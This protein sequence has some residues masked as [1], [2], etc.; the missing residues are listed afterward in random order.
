MYCD[1]KSGTVADFRLSYGKVLSSRSKIISINRN[2]EQMTKN[3]DMFWKPTLAIQSDPASF[4]VK[5]AEA[6][7]T[8]GPED[9]LKSLREKDNAKEI[10]NK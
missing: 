2:R 10:Q 1:Y 8:Q 4:I 3:S 7:K 9:W 5:L 6:T